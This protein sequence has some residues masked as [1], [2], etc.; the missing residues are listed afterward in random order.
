[1]EGIVEVDFCVD[2]FQVSGQYV[3]DCV[4]GVYWYECWGFYIV[5][6]EGQLFVLGGVVIGQMLEGYLGYEKFC[7]VLGVFLMNM[8]LL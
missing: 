5:V 4:V 3:F 7:C 2:V 1:M 8:V 6:W